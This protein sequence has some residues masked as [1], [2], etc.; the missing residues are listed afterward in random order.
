MLIS[1]LFGLIT[2]YNLMQKGQAPVASLPN[3]MV[4]FL[5][6]DHGVAELPPT[7]SFADPFPAGSMTV[8]QIITALDK[9]AFDDRVKGVYARL[10]GGHYALSHIEELRDAVKRFRASGK[11]AYVYSPSYGAEGGGFGGYYLAS[12]FEQ[13]WMQPMGIVSIAGM[14]AEMPF[15]REVLDDIGVDPQF[16]QRKEYKSAYESLTNTEMSDANREAMR[17]LINDISE[18]LVRDISEDRGIRTTHFE[19]MVN[20]GLFTAERALN[21]KLITNNDYADVLVENIK[22]KITGDR[23]ADNDMFVPMA[24]YLADV[25]RK[26]KHPD[27]IEQQ[28]A[29]S[30]PKVAVINVVGTIM[31]SDV[32]SSTGVLMGDGIAAADEI[33]PAIWEA[34]D[35]DEYQVIILRVDSPGGSP[36]ASESILRAVKKAQEKG[37]TVIV[38]MG[39][40]AASGGYWVAASADRIY[41]MPTTL[42]GSIGVVGG[43]FSIGALWE[44]LGVNWEGV[45]WGENASLWSMN[46]PFSASEA[47][48]INA[49]LDQVYDGFVAR[50]AEGRKMS[51][52]QVEQVARGRVW[53][54]KRAQEVGLVDQLGGMK[55]AKE[56]AAEVLQVETSENLEFVT[57][58]KPKT[59]LQQFLELLARQ[60]V[61]YENARWQNA[62]LG[63]I[64]PMVRDAAVMN[65]A[66]YMAYEPLSLD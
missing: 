5:N 15:F 44:K 57:L 32:S 33:T 53:S 66:P 35:A 10:D 16:F 61:V 45:S 28:I 55:E 43:K 41:A 40:T 2:T 58:P 19:G 37:K 65:S 56:Y 46:E 22:E 4:L 14:N 23:E 12:S 7:P 21:A 48:Q 6:L 50:V 17:A 25:T 8:H 59:T 39:P 34:A 49:M 63:L 3:E 30:K 9:A 20:T 51:P 62:A 54:G 11:F 36:T 64:K 42:T 24:R 27:L 60:G 31:S 38:S 29:P 13:I 47:A 26:K 52:A 18:T 1:M